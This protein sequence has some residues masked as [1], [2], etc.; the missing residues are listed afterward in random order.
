MPDRNRHITEKPNRK[1][2][3]MRTL[4]QTEVKNVSGAGLI[5]SLFQAGATVGTGLYQ[6]GSGV[7]QA[8]G[9]VVRPITNG[10]I[11]FLF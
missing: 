8:T 7:I 6:A 9:S 2:I 4:N 5:G 1:E 11:R 10:L 3:I